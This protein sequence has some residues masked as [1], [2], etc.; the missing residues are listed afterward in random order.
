MKIEI[1]PDIIRRIQAA[2]A[3]RGVR[4][5]RL[6]IEQGQIVVLAVMVRKVE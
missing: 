2:F 4:E 5:V 3:V 6:K 1:T